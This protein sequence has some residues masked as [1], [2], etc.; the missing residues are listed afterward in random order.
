MDALG[1]PYSFDRGLV[2]VQFRSAEPA[3]PAK[4]EQLDPS[5]SLSSPLQALLQGSGLQQRIETALQ[6]PLAERSL[7]R[8]GPF[9][10][11]LIEARDAFRA[12]SSA[13]P[14]QAKLLDAARR[15]L[16]EEL[17]LRE[18]A[19]MYRGVLQQG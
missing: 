6:P 2:D 4:R 10:A 17:G 8:P 12:A 16:D 14:A 18:L 7:L 3:L 9:T 13:D 19:A 11:A 15:T 1:L 5:E